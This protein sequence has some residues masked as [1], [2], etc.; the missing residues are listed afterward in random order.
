GAYTSLLA[1]TL[2]SIAE[3]QPSKPIP[4][5]LNLSSWQP[6]QP[7]RKWMILTLSSKYG[8]PP[9]TIEQLLNYQK[10]LPLLDGLDELNSFLREVCI[11]EINIFLSEVNRGSIPDWI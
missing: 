10:L 4:V 3:E 7:I 5:L 6:R 9:K 1:E 2:V 8:K 11:G